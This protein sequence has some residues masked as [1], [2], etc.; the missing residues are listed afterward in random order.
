MKKRIAI[1][2]ILSVAVLCLAGAAVCFF[3]RQASASAPE[4]KKTITQ[5]GLVKEG[6][7]SNAAAAGDK[8]AAV[9]IVNFSEN[10][11]LIIPENDIWSLVYELPGKPALKVFLKFGEGE[12]CDFGTGQVLCADYKN[13]F[14]ETGKRVRLEG[15]LAKSAVEVQ[16]IIPLE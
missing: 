7:V 11:N 3:G 8:G 9:P 14:S 10:G 12:Y 13:Y 6:E 2:I 5:A 15:F 16:K 1:F 4:T